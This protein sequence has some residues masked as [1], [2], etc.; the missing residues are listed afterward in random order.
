MSNYSPS[1]SNSN[2]DLMNQN[3]QNNPPTTFSSSYPLPPM[4]YVNLFSEEN[5][6]K[7]KSLDPP[8]PI[9]EGNLD[10]IKIHPFFF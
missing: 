6:L 8:K 2:S 3:Q 4:Q 5:I 1:L 7:G 10:L 9:T